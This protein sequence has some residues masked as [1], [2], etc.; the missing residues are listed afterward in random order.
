MEEKKVFHLNGAAATFLFL[1][2]KPLLSSSKA[3]T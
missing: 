2:G 3:R 1:S